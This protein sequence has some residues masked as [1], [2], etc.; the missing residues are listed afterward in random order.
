MKIAPY[1]LLFLAGAA[2]AL[3]EI[4]KIDQL[5]TSFSSAAVRISMRTLQLRDYAQPD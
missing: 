5:D 3:A 2:E 4:A 1:F